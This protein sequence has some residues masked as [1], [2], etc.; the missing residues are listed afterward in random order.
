M[1]FKDTPFKAASYQ[2][3]HMHSECPC[4]EACFPSSFQSLRFYTLGRKV[5]LLQTTNFPCL[6]YC[7]F[8]HPTRQIPINRSPQLPMIAEQ[9]TAVAKGIQVCTGV[10]DTCYHPA[11]VCLLSR[12]WQRRTSL[13]PHCSLFPPSSVLLNLTYS[14]HSSQYCSC[15]ILSV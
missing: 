8:L 12:F 9:Q 3:P 11:V 4:S 7:P 13:N 15:L 1:T 2:D 14:T 6:T 5:F 10:R